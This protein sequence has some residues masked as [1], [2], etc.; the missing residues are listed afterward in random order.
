MTARAVQRTAAMATVVVLAMLGGCKGGG[1]AE[2]TAWYRIDARELTLAPGA[3]GS[4]LV[5]FI[6]RDG[7]HWNPEFPA[8]LKVSDA[9]SVKASKVDFSL[10][11]GDFLDEGGTGA[12][13]I[14]VAAQ[15]AGATALKGLADFSVCN[16]KECRIFKQIA[17]EVPIDVH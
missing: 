2:S 6:P 16:D 1:A 7:Y 4:A 12:L 8:R 9:G 15:A 5:R 17:V 3:Q 10:S 11:N 14:P 13:T